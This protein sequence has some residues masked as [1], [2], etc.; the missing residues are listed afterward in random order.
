[1]NQQLP[2]YTPNTHIETQ[3]QKEQLTSQI[4]SL[5]EEMNRIQ[6]CINEVETYKVKIKS[7]TI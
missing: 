2:I 6:N 3:E 5:D 7:K 1:M 4:K